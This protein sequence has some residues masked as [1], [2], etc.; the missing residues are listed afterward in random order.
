[1]VMNVQNNLKFTK[2]PDK[3]N[4]R[5][6]IQKFTPVNSNKNYQKP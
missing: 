4:V 1:M 3:F 6:S 5:Q 2:K